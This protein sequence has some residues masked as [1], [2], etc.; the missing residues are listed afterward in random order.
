MWEDEPLSDRSFG[1]YLALFGFIILLVGIFVCWSSTGMAQQYSF[2]SQISGL[3]DSALWLLV[4]SFV[5]MVGIVLLLVG[6]VSGMHGHSH[7][8]YY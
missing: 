4:G 3:S 8:Y 2:G 6:L 5:V 1:A 7:S